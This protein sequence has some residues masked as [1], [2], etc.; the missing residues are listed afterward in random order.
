MTDTNVYL[1]YVSHRAAVYNSE[2]LEWGPKRLGYIAPSLDDAKE[3]VRNLLETEREN[4]TTYNET[5]AQSYADKVRVPDSYVDKWQMSRE[6]FSLDYG[7]WAEF[8]IVEYPIGKNLLDPSR[9]INPRRWD[10]WPDA[11]DLLSEDAKKLQQMR[12]AVQETIGL[13]KKAI[14]D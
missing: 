12:D 11:D 14:E 8:S 10:D 3:Y 5:I 7:A 1:V 4:R 2:S 6:G 13:L 9:K